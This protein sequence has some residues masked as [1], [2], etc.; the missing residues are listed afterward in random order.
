VELIGQALADKASDHWRRRTV[1]VIR[2]RRGH[3]AQLSGLRL[4]TYSVAYVL[5]FVGS[6]ADPGFVAS[7]EAELEPRRGGVV[8]PSPVKNIF[9]RNSAF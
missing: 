7:R 9:A 8:I 6:V 3:I 5:L 2:A 1:A 4:R